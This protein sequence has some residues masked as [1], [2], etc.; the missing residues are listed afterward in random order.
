MRL[1]VGSTLLL[2]VLA[3]FGCASSFA[4]PSGKHRSLKVAQQRYTE[5][6]RWGEIDRASIFVDPELLEE[7]LDQATKM[8]EIR[9]TDFDS[10]APQYRDENNAATVIV[11]YRA[12]PLARSGCGQGRCL[13]HG[14]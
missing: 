14:S 13:P 5:L 7:Y 2:A 3:T 9:V 11:V 12:Y 8:K 4:D 1:I 10:N 6:V